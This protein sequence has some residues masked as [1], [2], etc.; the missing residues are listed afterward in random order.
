MS[1]GSESEAESFRKEIETVIEEDELDEVLSATIDIAMASSDL[2]WATGCLIHLTEHPD[3]DVRGNAVIG[4]AHLADRFGELSQTDVEPV[5]RA[6]LDDPKPHV[7]EQAAAALGEL[8]ERLGW[9]L[10]EPGES[11]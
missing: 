2:D 1:Q 7:R 3:T 11:N 9:A 4:F 5:L 6:A 8:S 10:P